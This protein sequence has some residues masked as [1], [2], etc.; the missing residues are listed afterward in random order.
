MIR[1]AKNLLLFSLPTPKSI[2]KYL[3]GSLIFMSSVGVIW[4]FLFEIPPQI[5]SL[6]AHKIDATGH[7]I[8]RD[9]IT[10]SDYIPYRGM[11]IEFDMNLVQ[12]PDNRIE[13]RGL[14]I[15]ES[16][17]EIP[18]NKKTEIEVIGKLHR[19]SIHFLIYEQGKR[20]NTS[21][22]FK[23]RVSSDK[24][25]KGTFWSNSANSIGL[26]RWSKK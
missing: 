25:M 4:T 5:K 2:K 17:K 14:K 6:F 3:T 11:V 22:D 23:L 8:V 15:A 21:G 16:G 18:S 1:A 12:S 9:S 19:D 7:W 10:V 13:G 26:T 20:L 24:L